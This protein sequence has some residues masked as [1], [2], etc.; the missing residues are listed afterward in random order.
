MQF[1]S[2]SDILILK[3]ALA[4]SIA[5][6]VQH[7]VSRAKRTPA[8]PLIPDPKSRKLASSQITPPTRSIKKKLDQTNKRCVIFYGSQ[9]GTAE[10]LASIF[11]KEAQARFG[12]E[13]M[14]ADLEDFDYDT[15]LSLPTD[16]IAVFMLA[17]YGE[18]EPTDNAIA[19]NQYCSSVKSR[20]QEAAATLHY[21]LFGLGNS[22]YQNYNS[23]VRRAE[24]ALINSGAHCLGN[25]GF[26]DDGKG[27]LE[28]DF[29]TW[30]DN[31][32][33]IL[34]KH[35]GLSE[36]EN[37][38]EAVFNVKE[39][40]SPTIDTF[41]GE[42]NKMHLRAKVRGPYT[43]TN[44][45]PAPIVYTR[46]LFAGGDRQC[47]HIEF[48][49]EASTMTYDTG[50]HLAVWAS[51]SDVEVARFLKVFGLSERKD[52]EIQIQSRDPTVKVPVPANTTY[53]AAARYYLDICAPVSRHLLTLLTA[54]APDDTS[55]SQLSRL[56]TD[57]IAFQNEVRGRR[58]NIGQLLESF[59]P[60]LSWGN[61]PV[62]L[63]LENLRKLQPRYY[64][65][66][67]SSI[68][69]KKRISITAVVES[70]KDSTWTHE[71]KGVATNYLLA[72]ALNV[73]HTLL[74][75]KVP[76]ESQLSTTHQLGGP[77]QKYSQ[78]TALI[79][80]R[81]SK[82]RLPNKISTPVI[83]IGPGTGVAPFRAF[84][85]ERAIKSSSG[86]SPGRTLLFYGCR[87]H[88]E[89]FL[90]E[91]EWKVSIKPLFCTTFAD[92]LCCR[93]L[94]VHSNQALSTCTLRSPERNERFMFSIYLKN[95]HQ[96]WGR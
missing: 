96:N 23:M 61:V 60:S 69:S 48:D 9:T 57:G 51:N 30:K 6:S 81:R 43:P 32:L 53:D 55:R 1:L 5:Y 21:S 82:F 11:S 76:R 59:D 37:K 65:I 42:P 83:M 63:L 56:S 12:I 80:V 28:E 87:R 38:F 86:K 54:F 84:T 75:S 70:Q 74:A 44:P 17:T 90:Y 20:V 45:L 27:T 47:L 41:L 62:S 40:D 16:T 94:P 50:D 73:E 33:P 71:F 58:I 49:I 79:H 13:S 19:F 26:G 24:A 36:R 88:D 25:V 3:F 66:S 91:E 95:R 72:Q 46:Q 22:S 93:N 85:Q 29:L 2:E 8:I 18:G 7:V 67:S 15:L 64:S 89:D 31:T 92:Y 10:K 68:L 52:L 4:G 34:A 39:L 77:R 14:V 78:P 35:L